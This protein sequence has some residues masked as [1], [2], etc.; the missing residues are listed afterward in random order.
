MKLALLDDND[1]SDKEV[2]QIAPTLPVF[3]TLRVVQAAQRTLEGELGL[4]F[5]QAVKFSEDNATGR[6]GCEFRAQRRNST[7]NQIGINEVN[8]CATR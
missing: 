2:D 7:G 1:A 3:E 4:R 8:E 6:Y 5:D